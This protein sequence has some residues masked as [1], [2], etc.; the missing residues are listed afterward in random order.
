MTQS[1]TI[2]S[3]EEILAFPFRDKDWQNKFLI[4]SLI[5][6]SSFVIPI[7]PL[8]LIYGYGVRIARRII[9]GD[10]ELHTPAWDDWSRLFVDG[11]K[12]MGV[13]LVYGLPLIVLAFAAQGMLIVASLVPA[14]ITESSGAEPTTGLIVL[15]ALF[16]AGGLAASAL[17]IILSLAI[18][19]L[20]PPAVGHLIATD[21]F[22]AA[23]RVR[24]WW[25]IFRANV[26]SFLLIMAI[27]FGISMALVMV[28]QILYITVCLCCLIPLL[29]G[30]ISFYIAQVSFALYARAYRTGAQ[31][32]AQA[33]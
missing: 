29:M 3:L 27:V 24:E 18:G 8:F 22:A 19:V 17:T 2:G 7:L 13:S 16:A 4:G 33:G 32:L 15:S 1:V 11:A 10:G 9:Q 6:L 5:V 25:R 14:I 21:E 28:L 31:N 26:G 20:V 23:F 30:P 12:I